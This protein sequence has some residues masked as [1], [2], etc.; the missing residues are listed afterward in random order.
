MA[1]TSN[2]RCVDGIVLP[3]GADK[4]DINDAI[5]KV[6]PDHKRVGT[7]VFAANLHIIINL[8]A[9]PSTSLPAY[10]HGRNSQPFPTEEA[11]CPTLLT[12]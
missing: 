9:L 2:A 8:N 1:E 6:D 7:K 10:L 5:W 11:A 3:M 12:S 4:P